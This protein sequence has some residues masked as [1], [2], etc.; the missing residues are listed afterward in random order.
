MDIAFYF[1]FFSSSALGEC[2]RPMLNFFKVCF[3]GL[4]DFK[5]RW[6]FYLVGS[7]EIYL[8]TKEYVKKL[9]KKSV[10]LRTKIN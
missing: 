8:V 10:V 2:V 1:I 9:F 3:T 6:F 7:Y 5:W 4:Y